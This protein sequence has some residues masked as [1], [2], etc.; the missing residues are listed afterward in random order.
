MLKDA[1]LLRKYR[2]LCFFLHSYLYVCTTAT[3]SSFMMTG[4]GCGLGILKSTTISLV[5]IVL[6]NKWVEFYKVLD[7][8]SGLFLLSTPDATNCPPTFVPERGTLVV[9]V[10]SGQ[11]WVP[12]M[13]L[14]PSLA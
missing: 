4:P 9:R 5:L 11:H 1:S 3:E 10:K 8:F 2:L 12:V 14:F 7:Q 6:R 13:L